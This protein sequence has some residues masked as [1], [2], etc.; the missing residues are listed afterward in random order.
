MFS[1]SDWSDEIFSYLE[2]NLTGRKLH[3]VLFD[4]DNTLVRHDFGEAVMC[5]LLLAGVPWIKSLSPY[6]PEKD[7]CE[8]LEHL[9]KADPKSFMD[10]IWQYYES[11]IE[12]EGLGV[13]YRWSTWIFSGRS[14]KE[15]EETAISVWEKNQKDTTVNAV[16]AFQPTFEIVKALAQAGSKIWIVTASPEQVIQAVSEKWG[17]P[18]ENVL[19]M[20][21]V[22]EN[23]ILTPGLIEPFTYGIGKVELL[24]LANGNLGYDLA[25][26]D[27]ENDFP[28]LAN[29]RSKGI[30]LDR[31]KKSPPPGAFVQSV[32]NWKTISL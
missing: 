2:E 8:R 28:M 9:R 21:L 5:E 7:I 16:Q 19:G 11:K 14:A 27:S 6:F 25:F 24:N 31:G 29:T 18:R 26:G 3:T 30:F 23:G 12:R 20:R 10:G 22:E 1:K 32:Q 15:L 13:G 17:I 4:F